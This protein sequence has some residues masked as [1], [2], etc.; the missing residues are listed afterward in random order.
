MKKYLFLE[1]NFCVRGHSQIVFAFSYTLRIL[2]MGK[3]ASHDPREC[4]ESCCIN[5]DMTM[6]VQED[7]S[8]E[9]RSYEFS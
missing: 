7:N 2:A 5:K 1:T 9:W 8:K 6:N 3:I 4:R